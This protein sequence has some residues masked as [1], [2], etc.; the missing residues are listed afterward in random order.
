MRRL[1]ATSCRA[2]RATVTGLLML[3]LALAGCAPTSPPDVAEAPPALFEA[4]DTG[5]NGTVLDPPL[6]RPDVALR[7]TQGDRFDLDERPADEVTVLFFGFTNC[8]DICPTTM[9]DLAAAR[10]ALPAA[11]QDKVVVVVVTVDPHR[12]SPE[13]LRRWLDRFDQDFVGLIGGNRLSRRAERSLLAPVSRAK[14]GQAS[15]HHEHGTAKAQTGDYEVEH[16][17]T[18]YVFG[19]ADQSLIYTGGTTPQ[20]YTK[21]FTRLLEV[22]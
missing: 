15:H 2:D 8:E 5:F 7:D 22:R 9:A 14:P 17:G 4:N 10:R 1:P 20:Q 11:V 18:V 12:D 3:S 13:V 21:D 19:P 6:P 16:G